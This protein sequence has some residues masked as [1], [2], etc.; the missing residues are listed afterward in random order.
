MVVPLIHPK[1]YIPN[2]WDG[3]F[4][5]FWPGMPYPFKDEGLAKYLDAQ[6][7]PMLAQK[8][9]FD[10][11][12]MTKSGVTMVDNHAMKA[13]LGFS[14]AQAF[15]Q[16]MLDAVDRVASTSLGDDCGEGFAKPPEWASLFAQLSR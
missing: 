3:L 13:A 16:S 6:K 10:K 7:V 12:V 11:Y 8:Q 1:V 5:P 14:D 2:H 15:K 4:N 9:Y